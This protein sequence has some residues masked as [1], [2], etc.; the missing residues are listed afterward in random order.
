MVCGGRFDWRRMCLDTG[1]IAEDYGI[2]VF[3]PME[4]S[5]TL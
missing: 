1:G 3:N 4:E 5:S 2:P